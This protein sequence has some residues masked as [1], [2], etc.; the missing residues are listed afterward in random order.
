VTLLGRLY[1][2]VGCSVRFQNNVYDNVGFADAFSARVKASIDA[3]ID[4]NNLDAP[5]AEADPEDE[6]SALPGI[7]DS[8][9]SFNLKSRNINCIIWANGFR[10]G[11]D[12]IKLP[13]FDASNNI[14]HRHGI[15]AIDGLYFLGLHWLRSRKSN[16][17]FGIKEDAEFV[18]NHIVSMLQNQENGKAIHAVS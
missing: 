16:L 10:A 9:F 6:V 15:A 17:L 14:A 5:P 1:E 11:F 13:V 3:F 12:Y 7:S 4:Q 18:T 2:A 8:D